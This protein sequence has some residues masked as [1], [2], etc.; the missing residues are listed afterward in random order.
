MIRL[1]VLLQ[2]ERSNGDGIEF[3]PNYFGSKGY[4]LLRWK[5]QLI[6]PVQPCEAMIFT[7]RVGPSELDQVLS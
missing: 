3:D 2:L 5:N 4:K 6:P 7:V 1:F